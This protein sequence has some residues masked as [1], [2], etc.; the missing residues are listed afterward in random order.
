MTSV[1]AVIVTYNRAAKLAQVVKHVLAQ[2]QRPDWVIVVDNASTDNT[3]ETLRP[4]EA[5]GSLTVLRLA[6][7]TGGAGGFSA[8]MTKAYELGADFV[9]IMDDDCYPDA[10]ALEELLKGLETTERELDFKPSF[11][12]SVVTW[13]D[14][15]ICEMNNPGTTW[16]WGRLLA[17]GHQVVL[18]NHCSFVSVLIPRWAI[19][20]FGLPLKEYFIW[21]DDMEYTL[22]IAGAAPGVQVLSSTVVHD[23]G[24]NL[25]VNFGQIES[26]N[27]WK[28]EYGI[29]NE[30]SYRLH[31]E[32]FIA[33]V[34]FA[35]RLVK[36]MA[37]G[38]VSRSLRIR[39]IRALLRGVKFDPRPEFPR[40][41]L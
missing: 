26:G 27:M 13:T 24:A 18:V 20:R 2:T 6:E 10:N 9:W 1:A 28:Y 11:A 39:A 23:L 37:E 3:A 19:T 25:G 32:G 14:G 35:R 7:N 36:M 15:N 34:A 21:F 4:Y 17:R 31:H 8:G 22:R 33:F 16:D 29:R 12:C 5:D 38:H 41:V 30:A 40:S